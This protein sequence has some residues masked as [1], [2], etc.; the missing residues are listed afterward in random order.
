MNIFT[1]T[2]DSAASDEDSIPPPLPLKT[3]DSSDYNNMPT[4]SAHIFTNLEQ[5]NYSIVVSDKWVNRTVH[6][7]S[8]ENAT[9]EF[10]ETRNSA[11]ID[12]KPRPPTPPPKPCKNNKFSSN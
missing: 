1:V 2:T 8:M 6:S 7:S 11:L 12:D 9:Y 10:V 4:V 5:E 3:R